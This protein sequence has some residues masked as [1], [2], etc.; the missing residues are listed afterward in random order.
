MTP[1]V[2]N[3]NAVATNMESMLRRLIGE[4]IQLTL[5]LHPAIHLVK[6]DPG[7]IEQ[8][9]MNLAV[10]ARDAMPNGGKLLIETSNV[11]LD[12]S[13]AD[14]HRDVEPG[15]YALLAVSDTGHGM[16]ATTIAHLFEPFFTTKEVGK[17]T[18]LGLATV[19][20]IV[21]QTRRLRVCV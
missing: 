14:P 9:V 6:A 21:K 16:D 17:G 13:S 5:A 19:Y 2:L 12:R 11:D 8:V 18:G 10:N 1:I 4:D 3:L 15:P 20:G 7:Q